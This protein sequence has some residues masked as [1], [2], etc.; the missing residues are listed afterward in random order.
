MKLAL[1]DNTQLDI[2]GS[3][4]DRQQYKGLYRDGVQLIFDANIYTDTQLREIFTNP[5]KTQI[6]AI[7]DA[8][9]P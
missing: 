1:A 4:E 5:E 9:S 6:M 7:D 8:E 3:Y 2:I